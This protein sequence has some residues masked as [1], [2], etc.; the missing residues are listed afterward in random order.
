MRKFF[1][2]ILSVLFATSVLRAGDIKYTVNDKV[3]P[4]KR[5]WFHH[6]QGNYRASQFHRHCQLEPLFK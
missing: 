4:R 6:D 5:N 2:V 1:W 3:G